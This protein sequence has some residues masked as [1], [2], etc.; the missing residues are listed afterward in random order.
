M[1]IKSVLNKISLSIIS[2]MIITLIAEGV[3]R[4]LGNYPQQFIKDDSDFVVYDS[5]VHYTY[6]KNLNQRFEN[7]NYSINVST[8]SSGYRDEEWQFHQGENRILI[9]GDSFS[10]G[11]GVTKSNRY[12][13]LV[14]IAMNQ[15]KH[16]NKYRVYNAAVSGY[17]LEQMKITAE[18]VLNVVKPKIIIL[19]LNINSLSRLYDPYVYYHGYCVKKSKIKYAN[20]FENKLLIYNVSNHYLQFIE[21]YLLAYSALYNFVINR[22]R[23]L[24][25][26]FTIKSSEID[27]KLVNLAKSNI[28]ELLVILN[29]KDIE[30]FVLPII[31][32]GR[33]LKFNSVFIE[34]YKNINSICL[35]NNIG[36]IDVLPTL[37]FELKNG[38]N[39]WINNDPHWNH[40]A[41]KI[42]AKLLVKGIT[43]ANQE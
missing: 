15:K 17:N 35:Q 41:H 25:N 13:D 14:S 26:N 12:S 24:K 6:M 37:E 20:V 28:L 23:I 19:G 3:L 27:E 4:L 36:F 18:E 16:K 10:V 1:K 21:K 39:F 29:T 43:F 42:A 31:Q 30:L 33:D 11:Y 34:Y 8:N 2:L 38:S 22:A 40:N 5:S 7:D 9:V 32:H